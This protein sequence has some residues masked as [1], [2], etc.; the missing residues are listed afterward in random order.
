MAQSRNTTIASREELTPTVGIDAQDELFIQPLREFFIKYGCRVTTNKQHQP[1]VDYQIVSGDLG[2]VKDFFQSKSAQAKKR[3]VIVFGGNVF[4]PAGMEGDKT[5]TVL[6]DGRSIG[7]DQAI[8]MLHFFF[9]GNQSVLDLRKNPKKPLVSHVSGLAIKRSHVTKTGQVPM[10]EPDQQRIK[11]IIGELFDTK[12]GASGRGASRFSSLRW[13]HGLVLGILVILIPFIWYAG[14]V[15]LAVA[16]VAGSGKLLQRGSVEQA[17]TLSR[18]GAGFARQAKTSLS[19]LGLVFAPLGAEQV[20][21]HQEQTVG[22]IRDI[23][24]AGEGVGNIFVV[25]Q[26]LAEELL[27][28]AGSQEQLATPAS[29]V[30]KVRTELFA[31]QNNLSL[32]QAQ[33]ADLLE[34]QTFPFWVGTISRLGDAAMHSLG[35]Y[36]DTLASI[37][38]F[39]V[40]YPRAAGFRQPQ[41]YL[42]LLQNSMELRPS[43]GFIGSVA[44]ITLVDGRVADIEVQ[45]VYTLDG[46]LRGHVDPPGPIRELLGQE[47]WYLR[48]SNWD[49]DFRLSGA[50]AAWFYEKE[51]GTVVDGVIGVSLPF[52]VDLLLAVGP[53]ELPD[54]QDRITAENFFGKSLYYTQANFFPGSTQKK[55]FLGSLTAS[56]LEKL[57]RSGEAN[58]ASI[59]AAVT[60]ALARR[61]LQFYLKDAELEA[62]VSQFGWSGMVF[63][64][65]AT[66]P[67]WRDCLSDPLAIVEANMAV[68]KANYFITRS[69]S[70]K[71]I[72]AEDGMVNHEVTI[73]WQNKSKGMPADAGG[74]YRTYV[75]L[76]MPG[77]V[78]ITT[79]TLDGVPVPQRN[80]KERTIPGLPYTEVLQAEEGK[81]AVGLALEVPVQKEMRLTVS[82]QRAERLLWGPNGATY[83]RFIQKQPGSTGDQTQLV[84]QFPVFWSVIQEEGE[85]VARGKETIVAKQTKLEYNT[86]LLQDV[87]IRLTFVK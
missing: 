60:H 54:Y 17:F 77:D 80:P 21:R 39:L 8:A 46:Q 55:D 15:T 38:N 1:P 87:L 81:G 44:L 6:F 19:I 16:S 48:D 71:I 65:Q 57:T 5:K 51:T 62:L 28:R 47:H 74:N 50:R 13:W 40:L 33:L 84:V 43:G 52:I 41:T 2:F 25:S 79:V 36:R 76:L 49:S 7:D 12:Q 23:A 69:Q 66:C 86:T 11:R 70:H 56:L 4:T 14:S 78:Q 58:P 10:V 75:R 63:S 85:G 29:Q 32:A 31:V 82:Y 24:S 26:S 61:D 18:W 45:D 42:V 20:L 59:F 67:A 9:T 30:D 53:L 34:K 72:F 37:D 68:N 35:R 73:L 27:S 83:L 64:P 3:M 22:L